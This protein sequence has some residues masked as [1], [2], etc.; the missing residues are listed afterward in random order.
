MTLIDTSAWIEFFRAKGDAA[1]KARI[2]DLISFGEAVY[3]C[4]IHFELFL[5]ARPQ[6][7]NDLRAGLGFAHRV[8][9]TPQHWDAASALGA[10]LRSRGYSMPASDLLIATVAHENDIPLLARDQHFITI[11]ARLLPHLQLL[12]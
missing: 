2:A 5:G 7:L 6:E 10:K 1:F 3:T 8:I 11:R 12:P 4:P 9:L